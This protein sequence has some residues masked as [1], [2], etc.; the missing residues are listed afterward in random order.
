MSISMLW[1][2]DFSGPRTECVPYLIR[3][4]GLFAMFLT[5]ASRQAEHLLTTGKQIENIT[6][7]T[8]LCLV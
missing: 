5:I 1:L 7:H 6:E 4:I 3:R 2:S 8:A